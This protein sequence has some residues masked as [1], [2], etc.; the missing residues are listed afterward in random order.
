MNIH[1]LELFYFV[2]KHRGISQAVRK[3][4]YGIQQPAISAQLSQL[5]EGL[6]AKLFQRR[7]FH[8][9]AEGGR[10]FEFIEPFFSRV[11]EIEAEIRGDVSQRLRL[12]GS[13]TV[14]RDHLPELL[15]EHRRRFTALKLTLREAN[16]AQAEEML[17]N[18]EVDL[19]IT[20]IEGKMPA[21]IKSSIIIE[22][23]L[24]LLVS[25]NSKV[26]SS[27]ELLQGD[28]TR[29]P[30]I[31][32]PLGEAISR[33]F[34]QGLK[35]LEVDWPI[36]LEVT[37]LDLVATYVARGFGIGLSVAAPRITAS[38]PKVH[39]LPL[40]EFPPLVLGALWQGSLSAV[41]RTF[42]DQV[43]ARAVRG[44]FSA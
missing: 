38:V 33:L 22:L 32:L 20:E 16:Q 2:A 11:G 5:E 18:Q 7:P 23:P 41:A 19:A 30:L 14:L 25:K 35:L 42:L 21:G 10:L 28:L 17:Q 1:H 34:Q 3:M 6:G 37:S 31:S 44:D 24:V 26:R 8:L 13:A 27:K 36:G 40:R 4:P 43:R 12:A 9:T 29:T 15:E 39:A